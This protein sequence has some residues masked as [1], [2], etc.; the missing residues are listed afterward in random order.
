MAD[1]TGGERVSVSP[2]TFRLS[3]FTFHDRMEP[4]W[5]CSW[6]VDV[7]EFSAGGTDDGWDLMLMQWLSGISGCQVLLKIAKRGPEARGALTRAANHSSFPRSCMLKLD[8][9][10]PY[11][12]ANV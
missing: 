4:G 7:G 11:T 12:V 9:A 1:Q 5:K 2:F 8:W 3:P 6:D 10:R